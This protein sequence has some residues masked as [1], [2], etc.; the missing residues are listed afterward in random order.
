MVQL[1]D[2]L[3]TL[4][5]STGDSAT[6]N[7]ST[8]QREAGEAVL[9]RVLDWVRLHRR[10]VATAVVERGLERLPPVFLEFLH[11]SAATTASSRAF[12][13]D[14]VARLG[15]LLESA[16][17]STAQ[18]AADCMISVLT[19]EGTDGPVM[20]AIVAEGQRL[21]TMGSL[22]RFRIY[23]VVKD[24]ESHVCRSPACAYVY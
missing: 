7:D 17:T 6:S 1:L 5:G 9:Q 21:L 3:D 23:E 20:E 19:M 13:R 11:H 4:P 14:N 2:Y 12:L 16:D 24:F 10:D 8:G 15:G 22:I 18:R